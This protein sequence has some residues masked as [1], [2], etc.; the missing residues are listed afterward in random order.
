[1]EVITLDAKA[2]EAG[3][4]A[5]KAARREDEVPCVLYGQGTEPA[6]FQ[7][8]ELRLR[9]L[10][11]TDEFHTVAV[12]LDGAT[13]NCVLKSVDFHPVTDRPIHADFQMLKE[14]EN[15]S[16]EIPIHFSGN[17]MGVRNGGTKK[18]FV[19][20]IMVRCLPEFLPDHIEVDI[21]NLKIGESILVRELEVENVEIRAAKDQTL[22]AIARPRVIIQ[23]DEDE[24]GEEGEEGAEG[25][26][27]ASEEGSSE[28][29]E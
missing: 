19:N 15:I 4:K 10:I 18:T 28:G 12:N 25:A 11:Y 24:E 1:M 20:K 13:Y 7:V 3:K 2:R 27:G 16:I 17:A 22:I 23:L 14:G 6:S 5:A 26:E 8:P 21:T 29:S 9:D